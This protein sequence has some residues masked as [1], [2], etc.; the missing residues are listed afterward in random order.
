MLPIAWPQLMIGTVASRLVQEKESR[1]FPDDHSV[2]V[3]TK[4]SGFLP[5]ELNVG[6]HHLVNVSPRRGLQLPIAVPGEGLTKVM[7]NRTG[8]LQFE[9][10]L[11]LECV[12]ERF[13]V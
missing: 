8:S 11:L 2:Q 10:V 13:R 7:F 1:P 5:I 9:V 4:L 12:R 3:E 6:V